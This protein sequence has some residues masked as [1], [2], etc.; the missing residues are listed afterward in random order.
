[1]QKYLILLLIACL[2]FSCSDEIESNSPAIQGEVDG[3]FFRANSS[4]VVKNEDNTYTIKGETGFEEIALTV[5]TIKLGSYTLGQNNLNK[6][7][8]TNSDQE[9]FTTGTNGYGEI[10][11]TKLEGNTVSGQF[12]FDAY[13]ATGDTL[14]FN[15][16]YFFF[17][18][19]Q[20]PTPGGEETTCP[21]ATETREAAALIYQEAN[22]ENAEE[23][24]LAC[25]AYK[26]AL[27]QEIEICGDENGELQAM[28]DTLG[29]CEDEGG[30]NDIGN[31]SL[32]AG[33][34]EITFDMVDV[35]L[36]EGL[37]QVSGETSAENNYTIYFEVPE[38]TEG[39]DIIQN[40]ELMLT[41]TFYPADMPE[42]NPFTSTISLNT[43]GNLNGTFSGLL[44][45][46]DNGQIEITNGT[47]ELAY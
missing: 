47:F 17:V 31:I 27:L 2:S 18:P 44:E 46:N 30:N 39:Q 41:S 9:V 34:Q 11:I 33:S 21:E 3:V 8:F 29:D 1:M 35:N 32:T 38:A 22:P 14:N 12:Y 4:F 36:V 42:T 37:L 23:F 5:D 13:S 40:F 26:D 6:A 19:R 7:T 16:G 25:N 24:I 28:I 15:K 43:T 45:N 10:E 20:N